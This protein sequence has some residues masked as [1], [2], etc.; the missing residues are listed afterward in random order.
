[1]GTPD[2]ML[3]LEGLLRAAGCHIPQRPW[4]ALR[5][6]FASHYVM[7]GG[8]ILA[9]SKT[10]GHSKLE[11]TMIYAHLAPDFM[12]AEIARLSFAA[13]AVVAPAMASAP[14]PLHLQRARLASVRKLQQKARSRSSSSAT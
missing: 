11:T 12:A 9:L 5:H 2:D 6:T 10:L 8:N 7:S 14:H 13:P 1:M 4:H 3:D